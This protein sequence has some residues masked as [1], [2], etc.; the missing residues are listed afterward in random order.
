MVELQQSKAI[1]RAFLQESTI[2][3]QGDCGSSYAFGTTGSIEGAVTLGYG[4]LKSLSE[5]NIVDC[6]GIAVYVMS[7]C[8]QA[9]DSAHSDLL[10][11]S[12]I[13]SVFY[14]LC[15][16]HI[17]IVVCSFNSHTVSHAPLI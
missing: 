8:K 4:S 11:C 1:K 2:S 14:L 5:Q 6:S 3:L 17:H 12:F 16:I 13:H 9:P 10:T 15:V 7:V